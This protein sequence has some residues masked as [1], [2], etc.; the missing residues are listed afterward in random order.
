LSRLP[1][2]TSIPGC[3][4]IART[5]RRRC[6]L[7]ARPGEGWSRGSLERA[8]EGGVRV[9]LV[10]PPI[11][12]RSLEYPAGPRFGAPVG[13]LYLASKLESEGVEVAIYDA[14][15]DF[16]WTDVRPD[17][18]RQYHIGASW[19]TIA[20]HIEDYHPDVVGITNP[21]SDIADYTVKTA[22]EVKRIDPAIVT[23]VGGPHPTSYPQGFLAAG[24]PVDYVVRGEGELTLAR[25]VRAVAAG[26]PV[27]EI[28]GISYV[29]GGEVR[30]N[31]PAPFVENL[32]DLPLPAYHLVPMERYFELVGAGYP[33]RYTFEY[34]GSE[35]EVS[36]VTSRGCP[37]QCVYCGNHLHMGRRW[38][39]NSAPYVL[40]HIDLLVSR[41]G[42]RHLHVEDDNIGLKT[43]RFEALLDGIRSKG[44]D[45]TWDTSNGI[46]FEGLGRD[47]LRKIK[48]SGCTYLEFGI[49]A[50]NQRVLDTVVK[51]NLN[52]AD[53]VEAVGFCKSIRL[54]IHGLYVVGFPGETRAEIT[55]TFEFAK[56]LLRRFDVVPHLC[57]ARPLPGTE[58][59]EICRA[60]GYLTEP[61]L[62]DIGGDYRTEIYPRV[63][64]KTEAFSPSDLE[65]W[66]RAFNS[67]VIRILAVKILVWLARHPVALAGV[68]RRLVQ[69]APRGLSRA[70]RHVAFGG[71]IFKFNL[72]DARLR[73]KFTSGSSAGGPEERVR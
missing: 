18:S 16:S 7:E 25:L 54:D 32:D 37:F 35:R 51:K 70:L 69:E 55:D 29:E 34:R 45:I 59:D 2:F 36:I 23:V 20:R 50:G 31:A 41:Y 46:R 39:A 14:L 42:V 17:G 43:E 72:L 52:L 5:A 8:S 3:G 48:D 67:Q 33:S 56:M 24:G 4:R 19:L 44:W 57:L 6:L 58:L 73:R 38:R 12:V 28:P 22:A 60:G 53:V 66:V 47:L 65:A 63:M 49:D 71:L 9:L 27:E 15:V 64:I 10:R 61:V 11:R 21:Y 68:A 62:P 1:V 40:R 13:L 26:S 30:S